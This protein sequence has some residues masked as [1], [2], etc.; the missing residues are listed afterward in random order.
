MAKAMNYDEKW[1]KALNDACMGDYLGYLHK[2]DAT[3]YKNAIKD[4]FRQ[5]LLEC[6][7]DHI[8]SEFGPAFA[9]SEYIDVLKLKAALVNQ[10]KITDLTSEDEGVIINALTGELSR[11]KLPEKAYTAVA[12]LEKGRNHS[13]I[14]MTQ[15]N[16]FIA[17][18]VKHHRPD[19]LADQ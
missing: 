6:Y 12:Y 10:W 15:T 11:F 5:Y 18:M 9:P 19:H 2:M 7:C 13:A 1:E 17:E 16:D 4:A 14:G 8:R 3:K